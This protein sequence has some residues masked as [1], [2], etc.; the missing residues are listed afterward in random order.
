MHVSR[1]LRE[2]NTPSLGGLVVRMRKVRGQIGMKLDRTRRDLPNTPSEYQHEGAESIPR[3]GCCKCTCG[4]AM[5]DKLHG[6]IWS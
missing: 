1:A 2:T 4:L 5:L 3:F 6:R